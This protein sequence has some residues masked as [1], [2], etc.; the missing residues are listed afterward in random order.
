MSRVATR[1]A[2]WSW[3][4]TFAPWACTRPRGARGRQEAVVRD[5]ELVR[6]ARRRRARRSPRPRPRSARRRP[7]RAPRSRRACARP[8]CR[9][10]RTGWSPSAPS[11]CGCGAR[12]PDAAG[13][14]QVGEGLGAAHARGFHSAG[15]SVVIASAW[16]S[17]SS[18]RRARRTPGA[19][20]RRARALRSAPRRWSRG[21][22]RRPRPRRRGRRGRWLSSSTSTC[23]GASPSRSAARCVCG[24]PTPSVL[25]QPEDA[26]RDD[27]LLD[28][29]R[30]AADHDLGPGERDALPVAAVGH[31]RRAPGP[32]RR[33]CPGSRARA[34][35]ARPRASARCS[36]LIEVSAP[37]GS[38]RS[39]LVRKR[40]PFR[41]MASMRASARAMRRADAGILARPARPF[42]MHASR[43]R[44]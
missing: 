35:R 36:L 2:C 22:G 30:A 17:R 26:L 24:D 37:S 27:V 28:V 20:P 31:E 7:A 1:P 6:V 5:A 3:S 42:R 33:G 38:P 25:R 11:R 9:R 39:C 44:P 15:V 40:R 16:I 32:A 12:A 19:A 43:E 14:E 21:S 23:S 13:R 8:A 18:A 41:R 34:R 29:R 4:A 10:A